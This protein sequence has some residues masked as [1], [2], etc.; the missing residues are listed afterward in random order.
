MKSTNNARGTSAYVLQCPPERRQH[1]FAPTNN[2]LDSDSLRTL[3]SDGRCVLGGRFQTTPCLELR[4][5]GT[6]FQQHNHGFPKRTMT[7]LST[8]QRREAAIIFPACPFQQHNHVFSTHPCKS[9]EVFPGRFKEHFTA[10]TCL[11]GRGS[12]VGAGKS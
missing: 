4:F 3:W 5:F 10:Q 2:A 12:C 7:C 11:H 8:A 9:I 1:A 6:F